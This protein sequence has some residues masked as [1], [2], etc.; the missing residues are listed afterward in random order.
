MKIPILLFL[1]V[2]SISLQ[3]QEI[4]IPYS[5]QNLLSEVGV[6]LNA[7]RDAAYRDI[8]VIKNDYQ[9]YQLAI[10]SKREDL[11]IRYAIQPF[12]EHH[13]FSANPHVLTMRSITSV[14]TNDP[15]KAISAIPLDKLSLKQD[16]NA[17]WGMI[18]F[19]Q[20]KEKFAYYKHCR[21]LALY[22][23]GKGTAF[24]YFLFDES[25]NRALDYRYYALRFLE[26]GLN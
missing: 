3:A 18:Y 2:I 22:K 19:F 15:E 9:D 10:F 16:F 23:E 1:F 7:P 12:E 13:P 14:A 26:D 24:V 6:D 20:P 25:S 21:M 11:E 8:R 4:D 5:F 17:D